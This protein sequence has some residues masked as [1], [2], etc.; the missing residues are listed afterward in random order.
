MYAA[1][2]YHPGTPDVVVSVIYFSLASIIELHVGRPFITDLRLVIVIPAST[3]VS[4]WLIWPYECA[5]ELEG[6][7]RVI[8]RCGR[9]FEVTGFDQIPSG[10]RCLLVQHFWDYSVTVFWCES[11]YIS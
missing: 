5:V 1:V 2:C 10:C 11:L 6:S 3:V 4:V 8:N 9:I 7:L